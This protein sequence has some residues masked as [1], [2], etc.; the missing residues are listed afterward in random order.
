MHMHMHNMYAHVSVGYHP[1]E[2]D[3]RIGRRRC[4]ARPTPTA[5][6]P[7]VLRIPEPENDHRAEQ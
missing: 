6:R 5:Q 2:T 1:S 7:H 4:W 3:L